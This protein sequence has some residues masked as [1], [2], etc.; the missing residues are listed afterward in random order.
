MREA[1]EEITA[2]VLKLAPMRAAKAQAI[3]DLF[4]VSDLEDAIAEPTQEHNS[5]MSVMQR[6]R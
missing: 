3:E 4:L 5:S 2:Y 1:A 6:S